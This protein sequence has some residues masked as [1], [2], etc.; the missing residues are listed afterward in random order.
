MCFT[1]ILRVYKSPNLFALRCY[2]IYLDMYLIL[3]LKIRLTLNHR[4][5]DY[6]IKRGL[7]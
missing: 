5:I 7:T 3:V 2:K 4:P 6:A 1:K